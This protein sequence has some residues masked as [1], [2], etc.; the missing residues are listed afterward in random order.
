MA[1][2]EAIKFQRDLSEKEAI[3]SQK[4]IEAEG[5]AIVELTVQE[6]TAFLESVV[7]QHE[8]ARSQFGNTMFKMI[9]T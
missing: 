6:H 4:L 5:H 8:E 1:I 2:F 3:E 7:S 9:G